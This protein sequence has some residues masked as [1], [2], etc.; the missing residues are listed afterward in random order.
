M[1]AETRPEGSNTVQLL[2]DPAL[3]DAKIREEAAELT[4]TGSDVALEAADLLYFA[5]VKSVAA[6]VRLG[7]I[8]RL[9]DHRERKVTRRPMMA[10][11][12]E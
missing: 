3:L 12:G 11:E 2:D 6:G 7:D 5:L 9:L 8:E 4:A 1:I 10:K